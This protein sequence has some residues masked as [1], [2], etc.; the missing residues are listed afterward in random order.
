MP[1]GHLPFTLWNHSGN[2]LV[3][4][5]LRSPA[6]PLLSRQLALI[7][8]TGRRTGREHTLPIGY[9]REG[10]RGPTSDDPG[11][12]ARAQAVVAQPA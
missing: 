10:N 3:A 7:T 9:K 11:P 8:V 4:L 1:D 12:L 2:R 5:L 6:H